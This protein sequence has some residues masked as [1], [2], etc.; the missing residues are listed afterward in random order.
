MLLYENTPEAQ[1][2][3]TQFIAIDNY[4]KTT[5]TPETRQHIK[6]L[7]IEITSLKNTIIS[8]NQHRVDYISFIEEQEQMKKLG[9]T[10]E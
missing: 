8:T 6:G 7:K 3:I 10:N 9:I 1:K 2:L 5:A 4:F